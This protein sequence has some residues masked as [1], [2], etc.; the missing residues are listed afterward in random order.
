[1]RPPGA[2]P[3]KIDRRLLLNFDWT[4]LGLVLVIS[5]IGL[6]NIFS[7]GY[8]LSGLRQTPLYLK[9][10]QWIA[11]GLA[12][13][14]IAFSVDYRLIHRYAYVIYG[15]A[16]V[17]LVVVALYGYA[18]R[19]SQRWIALGGFMLQPSE[20]MKLALILALARYFDRHRSLQ[21]YGLRELAT[22]LILVLVPFL[23]ILRQPDLG[24]ALI[25]L[26]IFLAMV[27]FSGVRWRSVLW[28]GAGGIA[29]IPLAWFFLHD[30]QRERLLTFFNPERDPLGS[31]YHIIQSMIA[32]G[33][34]GL[35]GKGFLKGTQTQLK[36]LPEQQTDFVFS[37]F[38]EE[39]GLAGGLVLLILFLFLILWGL[40][41]SQRAR[42]LSGTLIAF[43]IT[44]MI[45]SEVFINI[46]MVTGLL[47]VVGIPLPFFSY[48]GSSMVVLLT[49]IG[50][51]LNISMRRFILHS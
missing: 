51:M 42:D 50:L 31:G 41:I 48:G 17:L 15:L 37:V 20:L 1:E 2:E 24:T 35:F 13:M 14:V 3:M 28:F 19:G 29:L 26:V 32:I 25:L 44:V 9:Q 8:S 23:L 21:G 6:M 12:I 38:A 4:L 33:S 46:G 45:F 16:V 49:G 30:Y 22:P 5:G 11:M 34:G 40:K 10:L 18:T 36:F 27:V 43:G 47:P 39:W 7:T